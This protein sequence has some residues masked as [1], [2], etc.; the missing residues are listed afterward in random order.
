MHDLVSINSLFLFYQPPSKS[1]HLKPYKHCINI[2]ATVHKQYNENIT[3]R[4]VCNYDI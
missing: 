3:P 4:V 1:S 2:I